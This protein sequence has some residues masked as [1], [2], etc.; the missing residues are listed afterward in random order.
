ML[1]GMAMRGDHVRALP[2]AAVLLMLAACGSGSSASSIATSGTAPSSSAP[3]AFSIQLRPV[4]DVVAAE[5]DA[6]PEPGAS[7]VPEAEATLCAPDA[8]Q[9]PRLQYSL[10]AAEL[11]GDQVSSVEAVDSVGGVDVIVTLTDQGAA[12]FADLT[13]RLV[14]LPDPQNQLAIVVGGEVQNAPA[15]QARIDGGQLVIS[16]FTT[17]AEAQA[18]VDSIAG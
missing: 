1:A 17:A 3:T 11:T 5:P 16:G 14:A 2:A 9:G 18:V 12:A 13:S 8:P 15:V 6:C 7:P 10:A 4:L